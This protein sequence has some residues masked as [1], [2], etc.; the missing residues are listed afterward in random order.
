MICQILEVFRKTLPGNDKYAVWGCENL[1]S[2][3]KMQLSLN[4][5]NFSDSFL[6]FLDSSSNFK[7]FVKKHDRESYFTAVKDLVRLL[8]KK[9]CFRKP[10]DSQHV[11]GSQT[12][13][14]FA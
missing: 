5:K 11:K 9:H 13:A 6:P 7:H 12:F 14:K 8:F 1:C 4:R 2:P 3:I 10:F